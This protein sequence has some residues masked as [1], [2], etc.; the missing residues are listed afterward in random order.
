VT[1]EEQVA[2]FIA[3]C[4]AAALVPRKR[5]YAELVVDYMRACYPDAVQIKYDELTG[6]AK[7]QLP[8]I[9]C[10]ELTCVIG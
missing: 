4:A 10:I 6:V 3:D 9:Q 1:I 7:V 5:T 8:P 2:A